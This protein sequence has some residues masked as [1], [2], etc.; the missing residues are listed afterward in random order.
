MFINV[1]VL[2]S[3]CTFSYAINLDQLV[4]LTQANGNS[5]ELNGLSELL[6]ESRGD[7]ELRQAAAPTNSSTNTTTTPSSSL[8][9]LISSVM[10]ALG[11]AIS[12]F[13]GP[14][15]PIA[16]AAGPLLNSA[17]TGMLTNALSGLVGVLKSNDLP[18][19]GYETYMVNVPNQGSYIILAKT[20]HKAN[21]ATFTPTPEH[22]S[23]LNRLSAISELLSNAIRNEQSNEIGSKTPLAAA[24]AVGAGIKKKK[25]L[26]IPLSLLA[27]LAGS[28]T[29]SKS[30]HAFNDYEIVLNEN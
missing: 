10:G 20:Q 24:A 27:A 2:L 16:D 18:N 15:K 1:F 19:S 11:S 25:P 13:L 4:R 28:S 12:P 6:R 8:T 7:I 5:N 23:D 30:Q 22:N 21:D 3:L 14:F 17:F 9:P 26:L 29:F